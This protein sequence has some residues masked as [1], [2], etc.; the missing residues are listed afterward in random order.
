MPA[1]A[2][3]DNP[4]RTS[5]S[6][7]IFLGCAVWA[8]VGI[9]LCVRLYESAKFPDGQR[10][11]YGYR[12]PVPSITRVHD[13]RA[14]LVPDVILT[15]G[16]AS[17]LGVCAA[18]VWRFA[19]SRRGRILGRLALCAAVI[20][21][22]V[23]WV[24]D[25]GLYL[26]TVPQ[27]DSGFRKFVVS[28]TGTMAVTCTCAFALASLS[29][30][31]AAIVLWLRGF[32]RWQ[33]RAGR[34]GPEWWR[35]CWAEPA[36]PDVEP[37]ITNIDEWSW[38][39][40]YN[41]P[42][43]DKVIARRGN[44]PV[45]AICL[46]G[47][48]IRSACV[49]MGAL[50]EFSLAEAKPGADAPGVG[51]NGPAACSS[52]KLIDSV[53]YIISVSGGG[54]TAGARLLA[55]QDYPTEKVLTGEQPAG[56]PASDHDATR[57]LRLSERF[58]QGSVEFEHVRRHSSYIAD[59][60]PTMIRALL[61]VLKN[62]VAS[63]ITL[64]SVPVAMGFAVGYF[65]GAFPIAAIVAVPSKTDH[66]DRIAEDAIRARNDFLPSLV[67]NPYSWWAAAVFAAVTVLLTAVA[68][69]VER[70][71]PSDRGE[72]RRMRLMRAG[73]IVVIFGGW[74]L[75]LTVVMPALMRLCANVSITSY[76]HFGG[77]V[78]SLL[79]LQYLAAIAAMLW[80]RRAAIAK[81]GK[82]SWRDKLPPGVVPLVL[83]IITL[84]L[85][86]A[87]WLIV[88]GA[89]GAGVFGYVTQDIDGPLRQV[90]WLP[91]WLAVLGV[92]AIMLLTADVTSLSLHPFYRARLALAFAV[93]RSVRRMPTNGARV[94]EAQAYT[95]DEPTWLHNYGRVEEGPQFVFSCAA[96]ISGAGKPAP[97]LNAVSY[98]LTNRYIGG[99]DLG[100]LK[101]EE[102][103]RASPPRIKRDL[104]V[105]AAVAVS[106]AAFGS[107]MGRQNKG[108]QVL[109]AISGARLGT[110][111]PNPNYVALL[112][113]K[114]EQQ[115][116]KRVSVRDVLKPT[117][118][119]S[120]HHADVT[121]RA[122]TSVSAPD[123]RAQRGTSNSDVTV[124]PKQPPSGVD[125]E[126]A[127]SEGA[128]SPEPAPK[129]RQP[130]DESVDGA[131][132]ENRAGPKSLLRSLPTVR[133][134]TYFY[135]EL[136]GYHPIDASLVQVTD[137]GHYEN[138]GL[139]EALRRRCRLILCI[140][141]GGDKPP[142]LS[143]L[144][145]AIRLAESELGVTIE[146]DEGGDYA[147]E[148]IAPGSGKPFSRADAFAR[149]NDR[150][151]RGTV[152]RATIT[153]PPASG[154]PIDQRKGILIF[155]KAVVWEGCPE[156]LLTYA[157][158]S[159]VF[160]HDNT[161]DQW[162]NEAQFA[163]YTELGRIIGRAAVKAY[164]AALPPPGS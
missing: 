164:H 92:L 89:V 56:T 67:H 124:S 131:R 156:W 52:S 54:Y 104:T 128:K 101:T 86:A 70:G 140:D 113:N 9:A 39:N 43:A 94:C 106:G 141:A 157:A 36:I 153:Y 123:R 98:V 2:S 19:A 10:Y 87:A 105:E 158:N 149:L 8:V 4:R 71:D 127:Q 37:D 111:L 135:R 51:N 11:T 142:L 110:W 62:L 5:L 38:V 117:P 27:T 150:I 83:V 68:L 12:S 46:S 137:G 99:P 160:P 60:T 138:L 146:P 93:R 82:T 74:I 121:G 1:N 81:R 108:N 125:G 132:S 144:A 147:A 85:L 57:K 33:R 115:D 23:G 64:F 107:T 159:D 50:Q 29:V 79:G 72:R 3:E 32:S 88:F 126:N 154:L 20:A 91:V 103:W 145:D 18:A 44:E 73:R 76:A 122:P 97:G 48:G 49:A 42:G 80:R 163:A 63:V 30:P 109:F 78:G 28:A 45:Q 13:I 34:Q 143:G 134:F 155:G 95:T 133:G 25:A 6:R 130:G 77:T 15:L 58:G 162:F 120:T 90:A 47:G 40:S 17:V 21:L 53:D 55:C 129:F 41:V 7:L 35:R 161:S 119:E 75:L 16:Y 66:G 139:V 69:I 84:A 100:W 152:L 116:R 118:T 65:L 26:S 22:A 102:L 151:T 14:S 136:F 31:A 114:T 61:E 24:E 112:A 59:S 148:N 96:A